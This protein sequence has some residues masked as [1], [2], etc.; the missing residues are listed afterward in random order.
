M[1]VDLLSALAL[2][3][4]LEGILPFLHPAAMKKLFLS[5]GALSAATLRLCGLLSMACGLGLLYL[6]RG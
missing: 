1:W 4:V 6:A 3:F 5:A 2:V